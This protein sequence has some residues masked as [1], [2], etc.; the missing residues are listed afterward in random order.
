MSPLHWA[1]DRGH[2]NTVN[3]LIEKGAEV[4]SKDSEGVS[5]Y[6]CTADCSNCCV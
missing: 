2:V 4:N 6:D 3:F 1:A 5:E